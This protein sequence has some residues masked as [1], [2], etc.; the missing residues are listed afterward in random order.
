[1]LP[2]TENRFSG[3][4]SV[5][6]VGELIVPPS[7]AIEC[8]V[9]MKGNKFPGVDDTPARLFM[10]TMVQLRIPLIVMFNLPIK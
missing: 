9:T 3:L 5:E 7:L 6:C 1:M 10:E 2:L 4:D 8:I